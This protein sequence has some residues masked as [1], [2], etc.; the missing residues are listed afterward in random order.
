VTPIL[1]HPSQS[2]HSAQFSRDGR[3]IAFHVT[4]SPI[5]RRLFVAR[6]E[7]PRPYGENEWFPVSYGKALDREPRWSP[8]G[9][10]IYFLSTRDGNHCIWAQRLDPTTK[11]AVG[12]QAAILHLHSARRSL[13][14]INDSGVVGLSVT[15]DRIIFCMRERTG[16]IWMTK[17]AE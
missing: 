8:N 5:T 3:W 14:N 10:V 11:R 6:Y 17:L 2:V 4:T 15:P 12:E 9:N 13:S 1:K 7:G 16:N